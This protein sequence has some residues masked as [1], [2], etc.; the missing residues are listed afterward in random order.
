MERSGT[1]VAERTASKLDV[2]SSSLFSRSI[3]CLQFNK[4]PS[5]VPSGCGKP[6]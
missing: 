6:P 3:E 1:D 5:P 4:T 2:E